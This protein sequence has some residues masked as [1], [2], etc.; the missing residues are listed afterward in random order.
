MVTARTLH[1][2]EI[3]STLAMD[4]VTEEHLTQFLDGFANDV[5]SRL[6]VQL[7]GVTAE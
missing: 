1:L 4:V 2:P 6:I 3:R 5:A 7:D